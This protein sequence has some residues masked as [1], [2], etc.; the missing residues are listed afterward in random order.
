MDIKT[1]LKEKT[2]KTGSIFMEKRYNWFKRLWYKLRGK[3]LPYNEFEL[4]TD[5]C[6]VIA[7]GSAD[8]LP[9][10]VVSPK[11]NYTAKE[12][13]MLNAL[14]KPKEYYPLGAA[15]TQEDIIATINAIRPNTIQSNDLN[16]LLESK[17]YN[18]EKW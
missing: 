16:E 8:E 9:F 17:F 4:L 6:V 15:P 5:S 2:F 18:I 3:K 10:T 7:L 13:K 11:K 1:E 14:I 12:C